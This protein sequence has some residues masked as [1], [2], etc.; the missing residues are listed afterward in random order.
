M[1]LK[2]SCKIWAN[3]RHS[4][5]FALLS[6]TNTIDCAQSTDQWTRLCSLAHQLLLLHKTDQPHLSTVNSHSS[7]TVLL[8]DKQAVIGYCKPLDAGQSKQRLREG[9]LFSNKATHQIERNKKR[10]RWALLNGKCIVSLAPRQR[11]DWARWM[12]LFNPIPSDSTQTEHGSQRHQMNSVVELPPGGRLL[13]VSPTRDCTL[14]IRWH[15][16]T[17]GYPSLCF[18][19]TIY[20]MSE[21]V[22][23]IA[24]V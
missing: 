24:M 15:Y 8:R 5:G 3:T 11:A 2:W 13:R 19:V 6:L 12:L 14:R 21:A 10:F 7:T 16:V 17:I 18:Q 9:C 4:H 1:L 22:S 23:C 20:E